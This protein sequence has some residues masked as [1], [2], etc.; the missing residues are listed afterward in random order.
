M[1]GITV[2]VLSETNIGVYYGENKKSGFSLHPDGVLSAKVTAVFE[3]ESINPDWLPQFRLD[4]QTEATDEQRNSMIIAYYVTQKL[5]DQSKLGQ[6]LKVLGFDVRAMANGQEF[7]TDDLIGRRCRLIVEHQD[8]NDG[9]TRAKV[10][11]VMPPD[12]AG[13]LSPQEP[14]D[15]D[16]IPF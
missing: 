9:S 2:K 15:D 4:F 7:D 12:S 6:V 8:K 5:T 10:T 16:D 1:I 11:A 14:T 3:A 13:P